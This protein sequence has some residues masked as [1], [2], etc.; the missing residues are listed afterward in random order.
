MLRN[1]NYTW[2]ADRVEQ[3]E[4]EAKALSPTHLKSNYETPEAV[5]PPLLSFK[6]S[7]NGKDNEMPS[8][9]NH[10]F[11]CPADGSPCE[12][13]LIT[14]GERMEAT[15]TVREEENLMPGTKLTV[16]LD[17]RAMHDAFSRDG[18]YVTP[19]GQ[20]VYEDDFHGVYIAGGTAPMFWDFD[21][22]RNRP[23]L[24]LRDNDGDGIYS[25]TLSLNRQEDKKQVENEWIV[26]NDLSAYAQLETAFPL[27][28]AIYNM[29]LDEMVNAVEADS[30]LRTGAEWG[31]VWTRD[32]SYSIILSMAYLQPKVSM[33]SLLRKVN[34][35]G[36]IVQDTGTGGAWPCSSD[37]QVWTVAAWELYKV[38]GDIEWLRYAYSVAKSSMEDDFLTV[39]DAETGL[40]M[41]ESSFIDWRDQSYPRWMQPVDIYQSKA[42]GTNAVHYRALCVLAEMADALGDSEGAE[43]Y[44]SKAEGLRDAVN[45]RL[46]M[47]DRGYYAQYLY[48]RT[49]NLLS[50]RSETLGEA[51][52]VLFGVAPEERHKVIARNVPINDFG[53]PIFYPQIEDMPP[54]H[55][56]AVW[57]FVETYWTLASAKAGN[58]AG[59]MQGIGSIYRAAALFA[60]NKENFV[61]STGDYAGTVVNS[62][63]MLWSLSGSLAI[64]YRVLFGMEFR[65]D[66]LTFSPFVPAKLASERKLTGFAYRDAVLDIEFTGHGNEIKE[67]A[68]DGIVQDTHSVPATLVGRHTV[69]IVLA[70]N[71]IEDKEV[72]MQPCR[73]SV[74]MP[75]AV[76]ADGVISWSAVDRAVKYRVLRDAEMVAE[77]QGLSYALPEGAHG[78]YQIVAVEA[79]GTGSFA[80]EPV[81]V[82]DTYSVEVEAY[83]PKSAYAYAGYEGNGFVEISHEMNRRVDVE[84]NVPEAGVYA[85]DWRYSNGNGPT[86]T[87]NKCALRTLAVDGERVGVSVFPQRGTGEWSN[88]G[89][90]N[91]VK[92]ALDAGLHKITLL[93]APENENMNLEVNQSL[94]DQM[95]LRKVG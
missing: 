24:Q 85:I 71:E 92:V 21:N 49:A 2:Y 89:W 43:R 6:F 32:V 84:I 90:S 75:V 23:D 87:D 78:A 76:Y 93:F 56:N 25:I 15:G 63:N 9:V 81:E 20:N 82:F 30:T 80:C 61:A 83:V 57:P 8:G 5:V 34:A 55:N 51:L 86:N 16:R 35:N 58:E 4:F 91:P 18:V 47:E 31:G 38:T 7:I 52:T 39:Y 53:A 40:V 66:G 69:R 1:E 10:E 70:D 36:R 12:T 60:T 72:N 79:D 46:W 67:F 50:P 17:M 3:G 94:I 54:Y 45:R 37:R 65:E 62:S 14:F 77:T 95:R 33:Y 44:A 88:W 11:L 68:V 26:K 64:V 29:S 41:G 74:L 59:V 28:Q 73:A 42:L 13:P 22:L 19:T 27:E 48:G